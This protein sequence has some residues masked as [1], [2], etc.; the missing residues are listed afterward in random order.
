VLDIGCDDLS[1][2]DVM[3]HGFPSKNPHYYGIDIDGVKVLKY[4]KKIT[5]SKEPVILIQ[6]DIC[7]GLPFIKDGSVDVIVAGEIFEHILP[8]KA[9][10]LLTESFRILKPNG[11]LILTTPNSMFTKNYAFHIK[12]YSISEMKDLLVKAGFVID[13]IYGWMTTA[14]C[15]R[16]SAE[17]MKFLNSLCEHTAREIALNIVA[18]KYPMYSDSI[19]YEAI[20]RNKNKLK[21]KWYETIY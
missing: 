19:V 8:E 18:H 6:H 12:E 5:R 4:A 9:V 1:L 16:Q 7:Y 11:R 21:Q 13:N 20:K 3:N 10:E 2:R 15:L 17:A 14:T